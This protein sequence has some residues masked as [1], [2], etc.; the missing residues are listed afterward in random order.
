MWV[1]IACKSKLQPFILGSLLI[2]F[3]GACSQSTPEKNWNATVDL[4]TSGV[5]NI[6][7]DVP[8]A[9]DATWNRS[10]YATGFVVD[11]KQGI[12]LTNRHVVTPGPI[13][14]KAILVNNEEIDLTPLYIDPVHDFGF[15]KYDPAQ[16]KHITPHEFKLSSK[17]PQIG[18]EI[19]IIGNDAGQK[20]SI[21]DGTISRLDRD[22]PSYGRGKYNDFNTFY[23]QAATASSG[24]SSG[25][26]VINI[27][28]EAVA[29][30]AGSQSNSANAF[31][32][33]LGKIKLALEKLQKGQE[34]V[35]GTI[36]TTFQ[37][38]PYPELQRLGLSEGLATKYRADYPDLKGLLV[39]RSIIPESAA[40]Q[41]LVVGDILLEMNNTS[42]A[43][44]SALES[45]LN[46]NVG[47]DIDITVL[48]QGEELTFSVEATNLQQLTPTSY[49]KFDGG[50]F[51]DLSYQ[52]ARHF[53]KP[54]NG[55]YVARSS[56][57]FKQAGLPSRS[58]ITEFN[59]AK[60]DTLEDFNAQLRVIPNNE[61]VH[62][63]YFDFST[64]NT[65]NYALVEINRTWFEHSFC[66]EDKELGYW[67]CEVFTEIVEKPQQEKSG[68]SNITDR[69]EDAL[70]SVSFVSPY[71]IQGRSGSNV[72]Y[73]TGVIVDVEKGWVVVSQNTVYSKAGD[74]KLVFNNK[75]EVAGK[76]EYVH[77]LHNLTLVSYDTSALSNIQVAQ[78]D[79]QVQPLKPGTPILQVGLNSQ[80]M[81]E[82]RETQ[83][84]TT[85][86]LWLNR[87]EV[88]RY[89]D[90]NIK[91]SHLV[92]PNYAIEGVFL[93]EQGKVVALWL[94]FEQSEGKKATTVLAG[95]SVDYVQELIQL[96]E[97]N[98][99]LFSLDLNLTQIAPVDAL[100][101][102]MSEEWL[103]KIQTHVPDENKILA[104]YNT[105]LSAASSKVLKR[106][107]I[108]LAINN[109]PVASFRQVEN[110]TQAPS[111]EITYLSEG[112]VHTAEVGTTPLNGNDIEQIFFWSGLY[113]H[114]PHRAAQLQ[115][116]VS[117]TGIYV[118]SYNYGSPA[119]RYGVY[120]MRRIVEIDGQAIETPEDF[121]Q[122]VKGKENQASVVI[123]TLRFN[124]QPEV[125]TL[126]LDNRYWPFI[127]L[128]F[129]Q[130][131]WR[132]ID[133]SSP[134][135]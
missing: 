39:V 101:M 73:G 70:V 109:E 71:A 41:N 119:T 67:P 130:G 64:P 5:V 96:A 6:Q 43:E 134:Q 89:I 77:P 47:Q 83:I 50:T 37:S 63:R 104:V 52:Q 98:K 97:T 10:T 129:E 103:D 4:V 126:K 9:F 78:I 16:I 76:I 2:V 18:E 84:D 46:E 15:F 86:E 23:I 85:E 55:V 133:H 122:A 121:L 19:R 93:N 53:N 48:R 107:D 27:K 92:N 79:M 21:L 54:V 100:Q 33:P 45:V 20:V 22:A 114:S 59:G 12:I 87:F 57:S 25:S 34:I 135:S 1:K 14:A 24:G 44:F 7:M 81:V 99:P 61:K 127:E 13:T 74:V 102:G 32:L 95:F 113:L 128:K 11:A 120:A 72:K 110:L 132:R 80:G 26:P 65:T 3:L 125:T 29:L 17:D 40:A 66:K 68:E 131:R 116:N 123:K 91:A 38:T 36:Q 82:Y 88:P 28:G 115:G 49:V 108:L 124:N 51:H 60:I 118:A 90:G 62:L 117:D 42:I 111:V 94:E 58:V 105:A 69:I 35:R 30:N 56:N 75:L 112:K 31:Y 8:I 106:G